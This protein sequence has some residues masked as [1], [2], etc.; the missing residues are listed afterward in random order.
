MQA[1]SLC[2]LII[3]ARNTNNNKGGDAQIPEVDAGGCLTELEIFS[4][5]REFLLNVCRLANERLDAV[6]IEKPDERDWHKHVADDEGGEGDSVTRGLETLHEPA[7]HQ[8]DSVDSEDKKVSIV[9]LLIDDTFGECLSL[10]E[11]ALS[12]FDISDHD[13]VQD[14]EDESSD[15]KAHHIV[16]EHDFREETLLKAN[17]ETV[18]TQ[19]IRNAASSDNVTGLDS[20]QVHQGLHA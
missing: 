8:D 11:K 2:V 18:S 15:S 13:S 17:N 5:V 12:I 1:E 16:S 10:A 19:V 3:H 7:T 6:S 4:L 9:G 20:L 14:S